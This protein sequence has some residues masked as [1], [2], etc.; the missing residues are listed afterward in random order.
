M[1]KFKKSAEYYL[2]NTV[3]LKV[4][5]DVSLTLNGGAPLEYKSTSDGKVFFNVR[6]SFYGVSFAEALVDNYVS[7]FDEHA[8]RTA[9]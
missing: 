9:R 5:K 6:N 2:V 1:S 7:G 8:A 3:S 4:D